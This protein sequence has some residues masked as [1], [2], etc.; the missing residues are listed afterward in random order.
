M[1]QYFSPSFSHS[2][3]PSPLQNNRDL[4]C[5]RLLLRQYCLLL[6]PHLP[7][8]PE[9]RARRSEGNSLQSTRTCSSSQQLV[10]NSSLSLPASVSHLRQERGA[11]GALYKGVPRVRQG[12]G[13]HQHS[14]KV[15][16][17][18]GG[19]RGGV[20]VH[21]WPE[22][23]WGGATEGGFPGVRVWRQN[24]IPW[25]LHAGRAAGPP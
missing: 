22:W 3:P 2:L 17:V 23:G 25:F 13:K 1:H 9:A 20:R 4:N 21:A 16:S 12:P 6:P 18:S 19:Q 14:N 7:A 15:C 11:A 10:T 24:V 5:H 8:S